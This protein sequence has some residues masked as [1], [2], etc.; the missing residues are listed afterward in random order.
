MQ[1]LA[2][3]A[4][5]NNDEM[6]F[7]PDAQHLTNRDL[8]KMAEQAREAAREGRMED[9]QQRMAEL[10]RMLDQLRNARAEQGRRRQ[11][12]RRAAP[13]RPPAD[14]RGA[15]H[16]RRGRAGCSTTR[17]SAGCRSST[18]RF[19]RQ[20]AADRSRRTMPTAQR[21][22]DRRV[23]QALRRALGELMQQFGDLTGQVPPSLGEADT[24]MREAGQA[25]W[26]RATTGAGGS[27]SSRPSR[28]CRR[29][30]ARWARRWRKQFGPQRQGED[31]SEQDGDGDGPMGL[32]AAGRAGRTRTGSRQGR[33]PAS[34]RRSDG[35]DP[36]GRRYG[37]GSSGAD[38]SADVHGAG[39][40][41]SASAPR[42][43]RRNCAAAAP[44]A[45][46]PQ[47]EL[48]YI[49]RLLKQF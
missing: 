26:A 46:R 44:N 18:T 13:A 24:A 14:G 29:A 39:G 1:A 32:L 31:G 27:R 30:A 22:A 17:S 3:Q 6:P 36:L 38:E 19:R 34:A 4:R 42:R 20:P 10:E 48:D 2:E 15:G 33:C 11:N 28:R 25:A 8:D 37:Q 45:P 12:G 40:D 43:S 49:D 5:R 7:D 21:E 41:A 35:R 47:Q 9:A 16:D 23:Q